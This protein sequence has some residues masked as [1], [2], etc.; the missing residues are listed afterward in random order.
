M[1][2]HFDVSHERHENHPVVA[3]FD[4]VMRLVRDKVPLLDDIF[5]T[6]RVADEN[7]IIG[8]QHFVPE[9]DLP[10]EIE[11]TVGDESQMFAFREARAHTL[12]LMAR[13]FGVAAEDV[14]AELLDTFILLHELG[15]AYD[16]RLNV[17]NGQEGTA[18]LPREEQGRAFSQAYWEQLA[19]LP[20]PGITPTELNKQLVERGFEAVQFEY[21]EYIGTVS[22]EEELRV[23]QQV[24]YRNL[25]AERYADEFATGFI[26]AYLPEIIDDL[27]RGA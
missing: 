18:D 24:S 2:H 1:D 25:P 8:G 15:H 26:K 12:E 6:V 3:H 20:I 23:L 5:I 10:Q 7:E 13:D 9:I 19:T 4:R 16:Y 17:E 14:S 11:V 21:A 27:E 22:S